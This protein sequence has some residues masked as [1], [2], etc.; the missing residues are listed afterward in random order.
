MNTDNY[1]RAD[2]FECDDVTE[3]VMLPDIKRIIS[4]NQ[5]TFY[6]RIYFFSPSKRQIH[7]LSTNVLWC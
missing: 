5:H 7:I 2:D 4:H 3:L 1:I 6:K